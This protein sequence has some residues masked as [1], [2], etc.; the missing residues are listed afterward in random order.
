MSEEQACASRELGSG[1]FALFFNKCSMQC[2][3]TTA[4]HYVM[5][6]DKLLILAAM[7]QVMQ[8]R[9]NTVFP[10]QGHYALDPT[11]MAA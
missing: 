9:L 1:E 7:K 8:G 2:S 4:R 6:D 10:R 11:A 3:V 5:V